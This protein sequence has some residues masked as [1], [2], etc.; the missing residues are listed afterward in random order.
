MKPYR[1]GKGGGSA[2]GGQWVPNPNKP[3][4]VILQGPPNSIQ[5]HYIPG[6]MEDTGYKSNMEMTDGL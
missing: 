1:I 6:K 4:E 3:N 5:R 2:Y